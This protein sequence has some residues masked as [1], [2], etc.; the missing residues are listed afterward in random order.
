MDFAA[1]THKFN[2][3]SASCF[4]VGSGKDCDKKRRTKKNDLESGFKSHGS[5]S[6]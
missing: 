4:A 5:V 6:A 1:A 2:D 3:R